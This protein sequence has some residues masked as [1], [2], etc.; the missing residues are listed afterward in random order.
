MFLLVLMLVTKSR[1]I[2][3]VFPFLVIGGKLEQIFSIVLAENLFPPEIFHGLEQVCACLEQDL[4][5]QKKSGI[6]ASNAREPNCQSGKSFSLRR[7][8]APVGSA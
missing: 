3:T 5:R 7:P 6:L 4:A 1:R 8:Y 2:R